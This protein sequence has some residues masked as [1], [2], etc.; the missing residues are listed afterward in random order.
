MSSF[1]TINPTTGASLHRWPYWDSA[2]LDAGLTRATLAQQTWRDRP[3]SERASVL[4]AIAEALTH[5]GEAL[6]QQMTL[7]MGKPIAQ[8]R[9]E[10]KKCA[11]VCRF[12]ADHAA[13]MLAPQSVEA[14]APVNEVHFAPLGVV[15]SVM[16]WNFPAWQVLRFAAPAW[17]AGNAVV[18]KHAPN[19]FGTAAKLTDLCASAGLPDGLLVDARVDLPDVPNIIADRRIAAVTVTGSDRAGRAV[20]RCAGE[21]LKKCVLELGGSDPF[22]VLDDADIDAAVE[23]AVASRCLNNG[24]SCIA[25]KRFFVQSTCYPAFV[26]ALTERMSALTVGDP[27]DSTV[28]LGPLARPDLCALLT[29]QVQQTIRAGARA[30]CGGT[31]TAPGGTYFPPTVLVDIPDQ[32]PAATDELFG[33]VASVWQVADEHEAIARANDSR[34]G[35]SASV[36]TTHPA[37]ARRIAAQLESGGVFVNQFSYSDPRLPFGGIKDSGYGRELGVFGIREFVN[38]KTIS[39]R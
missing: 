11:W 25:A 12:Y 38:I 2:Q 16:P 29:Q 33:P 8:A 24:Q 3:V 39:I 10:V 28:D 19:T 30:L 32:S 18:M 13:Q 4:H 17:M 1:T 14:A 37:R 22:I 15:F 7:E 26:A 31:P 35:L 36:W 5:H 23:A 9:G 6:A 27:M 21:H 20:A 34:F